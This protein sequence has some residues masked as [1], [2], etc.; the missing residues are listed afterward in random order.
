MAPDDVLLLSTGVIGK[1]IKME[2]L[3]AAV[4]QLAGALG[5]GAGDAHRA[6]VGITTTDL[7]SKSAALEVEL[8]PGRFARVGG[9][10]KGSGMIHPNM[11]TMLGVLTCDAPVTAAVWR[12]MVKRGSMKSFNQ[13]TVD[14][15]TSTNDTGGCGR[16]R[17]RRRCSVPPLLLRA[18]SHSLSGE[19]R[20]RP[21]EGR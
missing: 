11:A 12:G 3:L 20:P 5:A 14:G 18:G 1:R 10:A 21:G 7:V 16:R 19:G 13:I 9:I 4:P 2:Q 17:G 15:D 8:S 6:A